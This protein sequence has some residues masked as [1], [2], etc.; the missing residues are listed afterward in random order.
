MDNKELTLSLLVTI[1]LSKPVDTNSLV[2]N[3]AS[4]MFALG[5]VEDVWIEVLSNDEEKPETTIVVNE[6]GEC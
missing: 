1:E 4:S 6:I 3:M 2:T 5:G